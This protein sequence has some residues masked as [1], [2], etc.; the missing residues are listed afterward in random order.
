M[1][2][3]YHVKTARNPS[4]FFKDSVVRRAVKC[5][6]DDFKV[7]MPGKRVWNGLLKLYPEMLSRDCQEQSSVHSNALS[8]A[9][10]MRLSFRSTVATATFSF[11]AISS[12]V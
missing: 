12:L 11:L 7:Q 1:Q 10:R 6:R 2:N 8:Q 5:E 3:Y 9:S 4:W